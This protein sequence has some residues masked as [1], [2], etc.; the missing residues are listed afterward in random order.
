MT[1]LFGIGKNATK[2]RNKGGH[3]TTDSLHAIKEVVVIMY[4]DIIL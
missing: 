2:D 3:A 1:E 4:A